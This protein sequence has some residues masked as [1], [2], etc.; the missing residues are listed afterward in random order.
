M[1]QADVERVRDWID[2]SERI[3]VLTGAG[4]STDSGIPDFRG[5]KGLWTRNPEAEKLA[6]I[7]VYMADPEVRRRSWRGRIDGEF[8][9]DV[10]PNGGHYALAEL[11]TRGKLLC[12]IT[13]N[14]DGLHQKA[15]V[16]AERMVEIHG[17]LQEYMCMSCPERGPIDG[18]LQRVR[19]GEEDPPCRH[20]GGIL[21]TAA[22]S[23]GQ[24][25]FPG[26]LER[27]EWAA[28]ECDLMLAIGSTL[29]VYPAAGVVPL[30]KQCGARVVIVNGDPTEMDALADAVLRGRIGE[31]LPRIVR[32]AA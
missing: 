8:D 14:V 4:I 11:E 19:E 17:T 20:C 16:P 9:W 3:A 10:E 31:L 12:L 15:G 18:V 21:K 2:A 23:F 22:V 13:Q 5:P 6:T 29:A 30:A 26:D 27:S 24:S 28:R 1:P 32:P 7:Q 25:L